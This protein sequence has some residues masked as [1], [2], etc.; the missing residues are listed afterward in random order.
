MKRLV[1]GMIAL[2]FLPLLAWSQTDPQTSSK[3]LEEE[4]REIKMEMDS[5]FRDIQ[6]HPVWEKMDQ[7]TRERLPEIEAEIEESME[8]VRPAMEEARQEL[9]KVLDEL[10][11]TL[12]EYRKREG[13]RKAY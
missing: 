9:Q 3:P 5:L 2:F 13:D 1:L 8:D 7:M 12:E 10:E 4:L 11:R 6:R